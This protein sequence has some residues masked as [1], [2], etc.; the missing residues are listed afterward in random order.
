MGGDGISAYSIEAQLIY[1]IELLTF[2]VETTMNHFIEIERVRT[3]IF[4]LFISHALPCQIRT[5]REIIFLVISNYLK[6]LAMFAPYP[7]EYF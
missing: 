6:Q 1:T 7:R 4:L 5:D 3:L 2:N